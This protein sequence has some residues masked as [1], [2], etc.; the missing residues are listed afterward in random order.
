MDPDIKTALAQRSDEELLAIWVTNK[1]QEWRQEAFDTIRVILME[2]GISPPAQN[3]PTESSV[4]PL[5]TKWLT[6]YTHARLPLGALLTLA[7]LGT[8]AASLYTFLYSIP[9][10]LLYLGLAVGLHRRRAA[11]WRLN[12][13]LLAVETVGMVIGALSVSAANPMR[14]LTAMA[15]WI[16][17]WIVPNAMYFKK[18]RGL[19]VDPEPI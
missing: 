7:P 3:E 10:A 14:F 16:G 17:A 4:Q 11:A 13:F 5:S 19:F 9:W 15:V 2:R 18:R 12:W 1:T 6:V 8:G